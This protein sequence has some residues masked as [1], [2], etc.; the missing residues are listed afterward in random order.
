MSSGDAATMLVTEVVTLN[1]TS[2]RPQLGIATTDVERHDTVTREAV[3]QHGG[4]IVAS[5]PGRIAAIFPAANAAT[6]AAIDC[7]TDFA[8]DSGLVDAPLRVRIAL[9]SGPGGEGARALSNNSIRRRTILL[10]AVAYGGQILVSESSALQLRESTEPFTLRDLGPHRLKDLSPPERLFQLVVSG[11][12]SEFPAPRSLDHPDL[13]SNLPTM[14]TPFVGR[15]N[16]I[17]EVLGLLDEAR[18]VTL[19]GAGGAGKTRLSLQAAAE[20]LD[21]AGDGAWLVE[22]APLNDE[23]QIPSAILKALD[24]P[25]SDTDSL[26]LLV[27]TLAMQRPLLLLDNCE[28]VVDRVAKV[29]DVVLRACPGVRILAT[30]REP[31]GVDGERVYRVPSL[32]LPDE[33]AVSL[34]DAANS[35]AGRLF[36]ARAATVGASIAERDGQLVASVCRRLDGIPLA[37]E[38]A[39]ARLTTL[40]LPELSARLD[41]RFRLLT[42]GARSA[43]ARQQT[44]QALV[45][46]SYELLNPSERSVLQRLSVF[47]GSFELRAAETVCAGETVNEADVL[48]VIHSLVQKSLVIAQRDGDESRYRLLESIRQYAA[49]ELLR[50][51]GGVG[52]L[53]LR[54]R[55]ATYFLSVARR[56]APELEGPAIGVW[57]ARLDRDMDNLRTA[58][59]HLVDG[60]A[61]DAL[62]L[63]GSLERF[64]NFKACVDIIAPTLRAVSKVNHGDRQVAE[65]VSAALITV[66]MITGWHLIGQREEME[67]AGRYAERAEELAG[68]ERR[69]DLEAR[70]LACRTLVDLYRGDREAAAMHSAQA[71]EIARRCRNDTLLAEVLISSLHHI[72]MEHRGWTSVQSYARA[73]EALRAAERAGDVALVSRMKFWYG[74]HALNEGRPADAQRFYE[75]SLE[76]TYQIGAYDGATLNNYVIVC[77]VQGEYDSA[78]SPLRKCLRR[79]RRAGFRTNAGDLLA[80]GA[81]I[82]TWR[83]EPTAGAQLHGAADVVRGPAYE[84]GEVFRTTADVAIEEASI[85]R[86]RSAIGDVEYEKAYDEGKRLPVDQACDLALAIVG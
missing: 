80:A 63:V 85:D 61:V 78:I 56:A 44:L 82:A 69:F 71:E 81:C 9:H 47:S 86:T 25:G 59:D 60:R 16:E 30:S 4:S 18:L 40:S 76:V 41:E 21:G 27:R 3:E 2:R 31:L 43:M 11:L 29:V 67:A 49:V 77:L 36:L 8:S 57:I 46:W 51:E 54:D 83:G 62:E 72:L 15:L 32:S 12:R 1:A 38:L 5:T 52:V 26:D 53:D 7:Q 70:A 20:S 14:D 58:V 35:E 45:D 55:H 39:A 34:A 42:G 64:F 66:C 13:P 84:T 17:E 19:T 6:H 10:A 74:T 75:E 79:M 48:N 50:D 68:R 73:E 24:I 33:D 28:H 65:V 37:I 22:L 23:R